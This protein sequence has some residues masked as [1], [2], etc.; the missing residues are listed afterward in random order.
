MTMATR[1]AIIDQING[2][3]ERLYEHDEFSADGIREIM[4]DAHAHGID[5]LKSI[6]DSLVTILSAYENVDEPDND[7]AFRSRGFC[8]DYPC[9]G[10]EAGDCFGQ[11]YGSDE[12]IKRRVYAAG[13]DFYDDH[14]RDNEG[15]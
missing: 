6:R 12:S 14:P 9:C 7:D 3:T 4:T 1:F 2:Y 10:H 13:D 8:E 11:K 5:W 15:W